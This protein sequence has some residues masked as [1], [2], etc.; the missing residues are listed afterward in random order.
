L[1]TSMSRRRSY[2]DMPAM[3]TFWTILKRETLAEIAKWLKNRV[4]RE[5]FEY[6]EDDYSQSGLL[7]SPGYHSSVGFENEN[8]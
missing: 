4:R 7:S 2:Y 8:S 5:L 6:I 3:E 1:V